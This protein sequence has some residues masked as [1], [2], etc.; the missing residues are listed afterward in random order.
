MNRQQIEEIQD[1]IELIFGVTI[2]PKNPTEIR[3]KLT[4]LSTLIG[5][6]S[7]CRTYA[8]QI[9]D[10]ARGKWLRQHHEKMKDMKPTQSKEFI[11]TSTPEEQLLFNRCTNN[12]EGLKRSSE[13]LISILSHHKAEMQLSD[14]Q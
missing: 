10:V 6:S 14:Y 11:N 7:M 2:D 9:L 12:H 3:S 5:N 1:A 4:E 13:I 8:K